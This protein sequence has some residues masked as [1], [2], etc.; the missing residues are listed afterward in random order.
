MRNMRVRFSGDTH[1]GMKRKHNEDS[2]ILPDFEREQVPLVVRA[3]VTEPGHGASPVVIVTE[4]R[5]LL[6]ADL[7]P[8]RHEAR[9][10]AARHHVVVH[11]LQAVHGSDGIRRRPG[12]PDHTP[13]A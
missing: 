5:P 10:G 8:P 4:R 9:A 12:R 3:G 6:P 1:I 11:P 7:L 13:I 2:F